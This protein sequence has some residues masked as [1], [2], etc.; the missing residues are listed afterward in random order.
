DRQHAMRT[1]SERR[2]QPGRFRSPL[3]YPFRL[4]PPHQPLAWKRFAGLT[5]V[6]NLSSAGDAVVAVALA[7]TI[8]VSVP[9]H[10]ARGRTALGLVCTLLPFVVVT[11]L[12]G[13]LTDRVRAG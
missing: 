5:L 10:A 9:V 8:F 2:P 7:G 6:N 13:P 4:G 11:P 3:T 12:M 1:R